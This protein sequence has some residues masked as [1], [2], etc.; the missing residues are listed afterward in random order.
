LQATFSVSKRGSVAVG[1]AACATARASSA[2]LAM[3]RKDP[4]LPADKTLAPGFLK[5]SDDQTVLALATVSRAMAALNQPT[6][7][8]QDWGVAAAANLYGRAGTFKSLLDFRKDGAWGVTPHMI[9]H[10]S[11]HA[12]SGTISLALQIH[13]PNFGVGGGPQAVCEA[14]LAAATFISENNVPGLWVV[15]T[16]HEP[17]CVPSEDFEDKQLPTT[18]LA[19]ALALQALGGTSFPNYLR[20]SGGTAPLDWPE[21]KL[22]DLIQILESAGPVRST[23]NWRLPCGGW[24][25]LGDARS[26][27]DNGVTQQ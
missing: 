8:F 23:V 27:E 5:N 25:E 3:L 21:F 9:P 1:L 16:G 26:A 11:L 17:E 18:C 7:C 13:G 14:F 22:A 24:I 10:H 19:A 20:I 12:V 4:G 6:A 2:R 15:L